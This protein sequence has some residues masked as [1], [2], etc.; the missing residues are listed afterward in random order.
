[1]KQ[2]SP[3][4]VIA[5]L[6]ARLPTA[7]IDVYVKAGLGTS[8]SAREKRLKKALAVDFTKPKRVK[9]ERGR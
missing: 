6:K 9:N 2:L 7:S 3:A 1:M 8:I 4:E 5:A